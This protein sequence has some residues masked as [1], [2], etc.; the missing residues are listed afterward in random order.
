MANI[1]YHSHSM[2]DW[3]DI[4]SRL[5]NKHGWEPVYWISSSNRK[6]QILDCFPDCIWHS[7]RDAAMGIPA[8]DYNGPSIY[9]IDEEK[10][11][12]YNK[13]LHI[14]IK[15]M[16]RIDPIHG[17]F[18]HDQRH[19]HFTSLLMLYYNVVKKLNI[20]YAVFSQVPHVVSD[21]VIYVVCDSLNIP[22]IMFKEVTPVDGFVYSQKDIEEVPE[23][24]SRNNP[25]STNIS[26]ILQGYMND[27]TNR[28]NES[29]EMT[30]ELSETNDDRSKSISNLVKKGLE[31]PEKVL[32]FIINKASPVNIRAKNRRLIKKDEIPKDTN[33]GI[34]W[35]LRQSMRVSHHRKSLKKSYENKSEIPDFN[36]PYVYFPLHYQPE[37]TT[38]P[39]GGLYA[40]QYLIADLLSYVVP[41]EWRVYVKEHPVQF[42]ERRVGH[43]GRRESH[44]N[45]INKRENIS[46]LDLESDQSRLVKQAQLVATVTGTA[47]WEAITKGTPAVVFGN[48]WYRACDAVWYVK[49]VGDLQTAVDEIQDGATIN[50]QQIDEFLYTLTAAGFEGYLNPSKR[51][52]SVDKETNVC[53]IINEIEEQLIK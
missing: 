10:L 11:S 3:V 53:R 19:H 43:R 22:T 48:S 20:D 45:E 9:P 44:Y 40:H 36:T 25:N 50:E 5:Q 6:S 28:Q 33:H 34:M 35:N 30:E 39:L 2:P 37:L 14:A 1:L 18:T 51:K 8:E 49:N 24:I 15:M 21:Y 32:P 41:D 52:S 4:A 23:K 12:Y 26:D 42:S 17:E 16:D 47:G 7:K 13:S 31:N 46:L 27:L 38:S 29:G